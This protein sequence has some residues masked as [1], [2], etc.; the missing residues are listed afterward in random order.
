MPEIVL[1]WC[2]AWLMVV[3]HVKAKMDQAG[4]SCIIAVEKIIGRC[5]TSGLT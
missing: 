4:Q 1:L 2:V 5:A 3:A